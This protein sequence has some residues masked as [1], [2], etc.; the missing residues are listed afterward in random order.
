MCAAFSTTRYHDCSNS[1]GRSVTKSELIQSSRSRE[2]IHRNWLLVDKAS[3]VTLSVLLVITVYCLL[4]IERDPW[5]ITGIGVLVLTTVYGCLRLW[6]KH[7]Q[8]KATLHTCPAC[9]HQWDHEATLVA[10]ATDHCGLCGAAAV[11]ISPSET[12][13]APVMTEQEYWQWHGKIDQAETARRLPY[14]RINTALIAV[15]L[16]TFFA[17]IYFKDA[18]GPWIGDLVIRLIGIVFVYAILFGLTASVQRLARKKQLYCPHC[19]YPNDYSSFYILYSTGHC[20][21]CGNLVFKKPEISSHPD[22]PENYPRLKRNEFLSQWYRMKWLWAR[23]TALQMTLISLIGLYFAWVLYQL[24]DSAIPNRIDWTVCTGITLIVAIYLLI[25]R[26][27]QKLSKRWLP[28]C[29]CCG[30]KL[31]ETRALITLATGHCAE[32]RNPIFTDDPPT[33]A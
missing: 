23:E 17:M 10:I 32:C 14:Q 27:Q 3:A 7:R 29:P 22:L 21:Q 13:S 16:L 33:V 2:Q 12:D 31:M 6:L 25:S 30:L 28:R 26:R 24:S 15:I 5:T 4:Q 20:A 11:E 19:E 1:L 18:N 8:I 9:D